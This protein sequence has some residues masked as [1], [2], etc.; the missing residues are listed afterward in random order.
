MA[1]AALVALPLQAQ[2][3][4][5]ITLVSNTGQASSGSPARSDRAQGFTTGSNADGYTLSSIGH[6]LR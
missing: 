4:T 3:Q 1:F 5:V 6:R 2:A